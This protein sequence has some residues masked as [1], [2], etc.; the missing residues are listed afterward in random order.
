MLNIIVK[1][2]LSESIFKNVNNME[3][4]KFIN[5]IEICNLEC[6]YIIYDLSKKYNINDVNIKSISILIDIF[7]LC[8][9]KFMICDESYSNHLFLLSLFSSIISMTFRF[10]DDNKNIIELRNIIFDNFNIETILD[11][12]LYNYN[13]ENNDFNYDIKKEI[14]IKIKNEI[15]KNSIRFFLIY[16][17][18]SLDKIDILYKKY[19]EQYFRKHNRFDLK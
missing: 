10:I 5:D 4:N 3:I 1:D 13:Y 2:L 16:N 15:L 8:I 19:H 17:N 18:K 9:N 6:Y 7:I 12:Y 11:K 14:F